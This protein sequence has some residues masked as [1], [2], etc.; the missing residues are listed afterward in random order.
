MLLNIQLY[1]NGEPAGTAGALGM[2]D[3]QGPY[4]IGCHKDLSNFWDGIID[5]VVLINKALDEAEVK[6]LM[7]NGVANILAVEPTSKL[8]VSWGSVKSNAKF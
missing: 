2:E 4:F 6:D 5:E 3:A 8:A 7:D 1:V